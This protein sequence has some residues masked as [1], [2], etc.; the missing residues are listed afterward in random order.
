MRFQEAYEGWDQ[1]R[2]SQKEAAEL[3]GMCERSFRRYLAR[4]EVDGEA[5]L[6]DR[7]LENRSSRG[8]PPSSDPRP[9]R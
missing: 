1:G 8:P 2:L 5:G 3:L 9:T 7:R 4:Y 6:L